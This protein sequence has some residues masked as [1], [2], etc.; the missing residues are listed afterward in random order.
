MWD[1]LTDATNFPVVTG[2]A[3]S[4]TRQD[5]SDFLSADSSLAAGCSTGDEGVPLFVEMFLCIFQNLKLLLQEN[6]NLF[7]RILR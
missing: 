3:R 4:A 1:E 7:Y 2:T 5:T 6:Q